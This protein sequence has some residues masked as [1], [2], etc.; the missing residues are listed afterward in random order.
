LA[1]ADQIQAI[2][3]LSTPHKHDALQVYKPPKGGFFDGVEVPL[4]PRFFNW[5]WTRLAIE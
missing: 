5:L 3:A 4:Q 1:V 2:K